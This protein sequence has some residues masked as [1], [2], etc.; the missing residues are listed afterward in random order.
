MSEPIPVGIIGVGRHAKQVLLPAVI[1]VPD[2]RLVCACTAHEETAKEVE[3]TLR[4]K[5]YVG[6]EEMLKHAEVEAVLVVGGKHEPEIVACL[7]A[8]KH[9]FCE[10]IGISTHE[11]A[12]EIIRLRGEKKK[13]VEI[14]FCLRYA[15]IYQKMKAMLA[16]WRQADPS[17]RMVIVRYYPYVHHFYNLLLFLNGDI[18]EVLVN[19][20]GNQ[21]VISLKFVNGDI[22]AIIARN[23]NNVTPS[24]EMVEISGMT[25]VMRASNG[26]HLL[27]HRTDKPVARSYEREFNFDL[28][29]FEGFYPP[30]SLPYGSN[31]QV[32]LRGYV[33]EL[34]DFVRCVRT[35]AT[36]VSTVEEAERTICVS[37]AVAEAQKSGAWVKVNV[38]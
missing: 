11:G 25:G 28:A 31:M 16:E 21:R 14:A 8:G 9:V 2:L 30:F 10:T 29:T 1:Q 3:E 35:G 24:Y 4:L 37:E 32:Y 34:E 27:F 15:P 17:E 33:P 36:P 6:Y 5:C 38:P 7:E 23:F 12:K 26:N 13:V 19:G 20:G 18:S 22:G